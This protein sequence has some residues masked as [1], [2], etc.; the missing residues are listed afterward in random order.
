M[1]RLGSVCGAL[2]GPGWLCGRETA[3]SARDFGTLFHQTVREGLARPDE[4]L[5][6]YDSPRQQAP[7]A[8]AGRCGAC[9]AAEPWDGGS[10]FGGGS[11]FTVPWESVCIEHVRGFLAEAG[12]EGLNWEAA[13]EG[14]PDSVGRAAPAREAP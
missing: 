8:P 13:G 10:T 1:E 6:Y 2:K 7:P 11:I 14:A 4:F 9:C 12:E 5:T 3:G